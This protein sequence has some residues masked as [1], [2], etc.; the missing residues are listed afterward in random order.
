[1]LVLLLVAANNASAQQLHPAPWN[2][3]AVVWLAPADAQVAVQGKLDQLEPQLI[4]LTP[5]TGPYT[6]LLRQIIFYKSILLSFVNG[7]SAVQAI[8]LAIVEAATVGGMYE[9]AFTPESVLRDLSEEALA[10]LSN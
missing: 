10:L 1:M 7:S 3:P 8:D 2:D 5:G 6:V 9:R 4:D